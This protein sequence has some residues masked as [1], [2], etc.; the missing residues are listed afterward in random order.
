MKKI[1]FIVLLTASSCSSK[2]IY[3]K[4]Q[5]LREENKALLKANN[6]ILNSMYYFQRKC[7][8]SKKE[9]KQLREYIRY[10]K[11]HTS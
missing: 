7:I 10:K 8:E 5:E 4:N 1:S 9:N 6:E 11:W 3:K 2:F